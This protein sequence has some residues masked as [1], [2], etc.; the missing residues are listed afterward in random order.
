MPV[1]EVTPQTW[2]RRPEIR[3][4]ELSANQYLI[5]ARRRLE[6]FT[7]LDLSR[8]LPRPAW[9]QSGRRVE[10][11]HWRLAEAWKQAQATAGTF[12][13]RLRAR[14]MAAGKPG[15]VLPGA[16]IFRAI[17]LTHYCANILHYQAALGKG[18]ALPAGAGGV[19]ADGGGG[20]PG[21][22][23][24]DSPDAVGDAPAG[25]SPGACPTTG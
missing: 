10:A 14:A 4:P 21:L 3:L 13:R 20:G 22:G 25:G 8:P 12:E 15:P 19:D 16:D 7:A 9:F 18:R 2:L 5:E 23:H 11:Y 6:R 24:P 1:L 17:L